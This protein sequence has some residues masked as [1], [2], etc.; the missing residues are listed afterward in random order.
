[1]YRLYKFTVP[2]SQFALGRPAHKN[3]W[4]SVWLLLFDFSAVFDFEIC[5]IT[6]GRLDKI[7]GGCFSHFSCA[8][9]FSSLHFDLGS[10]APTRFVLRKLR[11]LRLLARICIHTPNSVRDPG[12]FNGVPVSFYVGMLWMWFLVT[13]LKIHENGNYFFLY[14][15]YPTNIKIMKKLILRD[16]IPADL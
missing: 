15:L 1:M 14:Y 8:I 11:V 7:K 10:S 5:V 3:I 13:K 16:P 2:G 9:L 6:Y 12:I 4:F